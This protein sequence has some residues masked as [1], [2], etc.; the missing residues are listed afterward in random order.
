MDSEDVPSISIDLEGFSFES[1]DVM[2][3]L[4]FRLIIEVL[5]LEVQTMF[6]GFPFRNL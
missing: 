4:K 5:F 1:I 6:E 2:A 3:F